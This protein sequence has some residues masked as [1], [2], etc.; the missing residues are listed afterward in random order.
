MARYRVVRTA[1]LIPKWE[2][3]LAADPKADYTDPA[4][5]QPMR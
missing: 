2:A 5:T 4:F 1:G 3:A